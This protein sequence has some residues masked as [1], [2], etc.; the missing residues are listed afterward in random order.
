MG[1]SSDALLLYGI[2]LGN[3]VDLV[4]VLKKLEAGM[5]EKG[6]DYDS[7]DED[8]ASE[9]LDGLLP[10]SLEVVLTAHNGYPQYFIA[11]RNYVTANRGYPKRIT[12]LPKVSKSA[13]A[14][15]QK[16]SKK[17]KIKPGYWLASYSDF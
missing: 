14:A 3:E 9:G 10:R 1:I 2:N 5:Y 8:D 15:L 12:R 16:V 11:P 6:F 4:S 7:M 13:R 17:L